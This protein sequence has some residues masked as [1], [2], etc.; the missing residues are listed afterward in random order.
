MVRRSRPGCNN[1]ST[2][3]TS[4][5]E[6]GA[7]TTGTDRNKQRAEPLCL[8]AALDYLRRGWS[9]IAVC[10]P[11]H[12]GVPG[13]HEKQCKKPGKAPWYDHSPY[14]TTRARPEQ[15]RMWWTR[16]P[17]ANVGVCLGPVSGLVRLDVDN[18]EG[19]T[20]LGQLGTIP[21]T[22]TFST[23]GGGTGYLFALADGE[24]PGNWSL[25]GHSGGE[26]LRLQSKGLQT[27]MPPSVHAS[28]RPY[29]WWPD[30][31]P[32]QV[33]AAPL[34]A[35]LANKP[36]PP[37]PKPTPKP[38]PVSIPEVLRLRARR[39][40]D[41]MGVCD[42]RPDHPMDASTHLL[43]AANA[44]AIGF[45]LDDDTCVSLLAEWD[46]ANP[47]GAYPEK[48][49]RRKLAAARAK[50]NGAPGYLLNESGPLPGLG[51]A[52]ANGHR[53]YETN[54][55]SNGNGT[56]RKPRSEAPKRP[57]RLLAPYQPFPVDALP[58]PLAAYVRQ[59]AA[60][61]GCD[62]A[63]VALPTLAVVA[64]AIGNTRTIQ[65][66]RGWQEP[67]V[68]WTSII[69]DSGTLKSPA[70]QKAVNYFQKV[71]R[72]LLLEYKAARTRYAQALAEFKE[73]KRQARESGIDTGD[74]PQEPVLK[75]VVCSDI[76]IEK[77]AEILEDNHRG[78]LMARDEL[79]GWL[80]SF[81]RYK[82]QSGGSDLP[83]WLEMHRAG[84]IMTDRKTGERRHLFVPRAAVSVCGGIQPGVLARA[85][86]PEF[87][88]AG[89]AARLLLA[90][91]PK[92]PKHWSE[93]EVEPAVEQLYE[94][95]LDALLALDLDRQGGELVPHVLKLAPEAKDAWVAFYDRW[96]QE[97][98]AVEGDL[99]A[100]FSKLEAYAARFAL[101]HHVVSHV[102]VDSSDLRPVGRKSV[103]AGVCLCEWFGA[104]ARRI[105]SALAESGHERTTR[106]L[107]EFIQARGGSI[108]AR[109]LQKSNSRKY[110]RCD[111]A[112]AALEALVE[113]GA[114]EWT[115]SQTTTRGGRPTRAFSIR[116]TPDTTDTTWESGEGE[117]EH[118]AEE[119][120]D[121]TSDTTAPSTEKPEES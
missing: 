110:P 108:T 43:K 30:C 85:M 96:G 79:A 97:Q 31:A 52:P 70:H 15:L 17:G 94:N 37:Q 46:A 73:S 38:A 55:G 5:A 83:N 9:A 35:W 118:P 116:P 69:G 60:A 68:I 93:D 104:E 2:S 53:R 88:E 62:P 109:D 45:R 61:L 41:T 19:E 82:S 44:L 98:V 84:T 10:P 54:G 47:S 20:L 78:V 24:D 49:Y 13:G 107:V 25:R 120:T 21:H 72:R 4:G 23:G 1:Q 101:V 36:Q 67:S 18:Q 115:W 33:E 42:P 39:Y 28:G 117:E 89:L 7:V 102:G 99:A 113:A 114:G 16:C 66:R 100:A 48:E 112:E 121:T 111:I 74:A 77:L 76:T 95:T 58:A 3:P 50:P 80:G 26:A 29:A 119:A 40:L 12:A 8:A 75:R 11:N 64:S 71:Q 91:P 103:E 90:M 14:F 81:T 56:P 57:V 27:V 65:L 6:P 105:Y 59:A 22:L 63:Y 32:G 92:L 34:P 106:Q 87:L 51:S 86:T